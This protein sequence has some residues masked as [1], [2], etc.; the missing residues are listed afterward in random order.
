MPWESGISFGIVPLSN[1]V[2]LG[3]VPCINETFLGI[4][5]SMCIGEISVPFGG[6]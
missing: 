4:M 6:V 3:A 2:D 1:L 5:P